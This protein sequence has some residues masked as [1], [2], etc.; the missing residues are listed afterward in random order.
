MIKLIDYINV[1]CIMVNICS[2]KRL[3]VCLCLVSAIIYLALQWNFVCSNRE[4][5]TLISN[6]CEDVESGQAI[7]SLC[8]EFCSGAL[9]SHIC[10]AFHG[11]KEVVFSAQFHGNSVYVKGRKSDIYKNQ[12]ENLFWKDENGTEHFP[13]IS[14]FK[15]IVKAHLLHNFNVTYSERVFYNLWKP[16]IKVESFSSTQNLLLQKLS[17]K[18]LWGLL[19]DP[20]FVTLSVFQHVDIFPEL[21]GTCG[22]FY[23]VEELKHIQYPSFVPSSNFKI[24]V[25]N[26]KIALGILDLLTVLDNSFG[27]PVY[28]C[29]VKKDHFG[30]SDFG[31]VK[32]LDLD[33]VYLKSIID[34]SI[35]ETTLCE[36]HSDCD[37]FDCKGSCDLV[38][39]KCFTG[40]TNN[41]LQNICEKI[42]LGTVTGFDGYSNGL[43]SSS[44][45]TKALMNLLNECSNPSSAKDGAR[46]FADEFVKQKL[47]ITLKEIIVADSRLMKDIL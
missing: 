38:R 29:D 2:L 23:V 6:L 32:V 15:T 33:N 16:P 46:T 22:G 42:F 20:E 18:T 19:Q 10:E 44:H 21:Y 40:V 25:K 26:V 3:F 45:S 9:N 1:Y 36:K 31:K 11:G 34:R 47:K 17:L 35:G 27:E 14:E 30:I 43:L 8:K 28:L 24:F 12:E 39:H 41:N 37:F 4:T 5:Q 13:S 7:G